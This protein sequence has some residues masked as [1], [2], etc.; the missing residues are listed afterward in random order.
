MSFINTIEDDSDQVELIVR[1][2]F[3]AKPGCNIV[4]FDAYDQS[5][6]VTE[7]STQLSSNSSR[8]DGIIASLSDTDANV[9][10][11][12]SNLLT[13]IANT[14]SNTVTNASLVSG[15]RA[16]V[17]LNSALT[18]NLQA[19][20]ASN[21]A[22]VSGLRTDLDANSTLLGNTTA[23]ITVVEQNTSNL[24][25]LTNTVSEHT[26][27][28]LNLEQ[29]VNLLD[30]I[31]GALDGNSSALA[32]LT[33]ASVSW[34]LTLFNAVD[35]AATKVKLDQTRDTI[36]EVFG[37][38]S[39]N[40]ENISSSNGYSLTNNSNITQL[41]NQMTLVRAHTDTTSVRQIKIN[42]NSSNI[43]SLQSNTAQ[44]AT[45]INI[46]T[47]NI[48]SLNQ[49][50]NTIETD[51]N[52]LTSSLSDNSSRIT[53]V[54][55]DLASNSARISTVTSD[56]ASNVSRISSLENSGGMSSG[57]GV[58]QL[59]TITKSLQ[60]TSGWMDTGIQGTD[61]T[62]GTHIV[63]IYDVDD[64]TAGGGDYDEIYSGIMSWFSGHTNSYEATEIHLTSAG[65][66]PNDNHIYLRVLR[67]PYNNGTGRCKLQIRRDSGMSGSYTYTFKFRRLI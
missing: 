14:A 18:S 27:D 47:S 12:N 2:R 41:Q 28:I 51:I 67:T 23:R 63:Q 43:T 62:S 40:W 54:S 29:S 22:L 20:L 3:E 45:A 52:S 9:I 10:A 11:L 56:L 55:G 64:H 35:K 57:T 1:Q 60:I 7:L 42:G 50:I 66:A 59:N 34:A 30:S 46:H 61:L 16:D 31:E 17:D 13:A 4:G 33:G 21:S 15:L 58:D 53:T 48:G 37:T 38:T 49:S 32:A 19:D 44:L 24:S 5:N 6:A 25:N 8:I 65:H 36:A 39:N 26:T